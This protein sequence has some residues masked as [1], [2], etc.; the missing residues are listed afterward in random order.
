M[1][2]KIRVL[3]IALAFVLA[4]GA[5][6]QL[7]SVQTLEVLDADPCDSAL[8]EDYPAIG[9]SVFWESGVM[10]ALFEAGFIVSSMPLAR[11]DGI[12]IGEPVDASLLALE[13]AREA[14][15]D[16]LI[17]LVIVYDAC[18]SSGELRGVSTL[19]PVAL[20]WEL[21]Y[22]SRKES[23]GRR[24]VWKLEASRS[25]REVVRQAEGLGRTIISGLNG[26]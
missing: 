5:H 7:V 1:L 6:A 12:N 23:A 16:V 13:Q 25:D 3:A 26:R 19:R 17:C 11:V 15:V 18:T 2:E 24:G 8:L 21:Y 14:G 20:S 4:A 9:H 22:P 10:N